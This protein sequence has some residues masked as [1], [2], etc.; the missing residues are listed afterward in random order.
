[1]VEEEE[2]EEES[3]VHKKVPKEVKL[4]HHKKTAVVAEKIKANKS[5]T[6]FKR[7]NSANPSVYEGGLVPVPEVSGKEDDDYDKLKA[8]IVHT[9]IDYRVYKNE[10]LESLFGRIMLYNKHL[11]PLRLQDLL[12][13]IK[14]EFEK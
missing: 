7:I 4:Y 13:Y 14:E 10:D 11:D 3:K 8:K 1:M 12:E 2:E 6:G 5:S 9:I